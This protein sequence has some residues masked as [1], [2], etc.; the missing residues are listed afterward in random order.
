M[1]KKEEVL[2]RFAEHSRKRLKER[3][4]KFLS[5][6]PINCF[7]NDKI[8]IHGKGQIRFC[9]NPEI[10]KGLQDGCFY[11]CDNIQTVQKCNKFF[12]KN[13]IN[14]VENTFYEILSSPSRCGLEYPKLAMLIWFLQEEVD[15]IAPIV[16][17]KWWQK[18]ILWKKKH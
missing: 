13:T 11:P 17:K 1:R 10:L 7:Y 5:R 15:S 6:I 3:K 9:R 16:E 18:I 14:S 4:E 12:C 8:S 2:L